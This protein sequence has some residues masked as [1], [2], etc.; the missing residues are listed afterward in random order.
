MPLQA[1]FIIII[2]IRGYESGQYSVNILHRNNS[3][4]LSVR[5]DKTQNNCGFM[6]VYIY[7]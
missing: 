2:I 1:Y 7:I 4:F 6:G 3:H 5:V